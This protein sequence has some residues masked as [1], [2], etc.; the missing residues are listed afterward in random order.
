LGRDAHFAPPRSSLREA[1]A[2]EDK[3]LR[4][5]LIIGLAIAAQALPAQIP[6]VELPDQPF[7]LTGFMK[8]ESSRQ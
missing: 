7:K 6:A 1:T 5:I 3:V 8:T 4:D 2:Q